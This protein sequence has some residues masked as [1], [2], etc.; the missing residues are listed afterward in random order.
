MTLRRTTIKVLHE[1][2]TNP[3]PDGRRRDDWTGEKTFR[4][5]RYIVDDVCISKVK[6]GRYHRILRGQRGETVTYDTLAP[7]LTEVAPNG[8]REL[9]LTLGSEDNATHILGV[10]LQNG[11]ITADQIEKAAITLDE[12]EEDFWDAL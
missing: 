10:L 11:S 8:I 1:P 7:A 4:P 9:L 12:S 5:G 6:G 3:T 2:I